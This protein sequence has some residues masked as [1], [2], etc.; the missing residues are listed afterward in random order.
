M[1]P[2]S[3]WREHP[4]EYAGK[5]VGEKVEVIREKMKEKKGTREKKPSF[6]NNPLTNMHSLT[7]F[8]PQQR[9]LLYTLIFRKYRTF[10]ISAVPIFPAVQSVNPT[11]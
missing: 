8:L 11:A 1:S 10:S 3:V 6:K 7:T 5:N 9:T 2:R 4:I